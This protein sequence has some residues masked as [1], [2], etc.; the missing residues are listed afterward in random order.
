MTRSKLRSVLFIFAAHVNLNNM[1]NIS[2]TL[3]L[4]GR[5]SCEIFGVLF[6][7]IMDQIFTSCNLWLGR[8]KKRTVK[9]NMMI[10]ICGRVCVA[11]EAVRNLRTD[12]I[13]LFF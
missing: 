8:R 2:N 9:S 3:Q 7:K 10:Q 4:Q 13:F 6:L 1:L 11:L 12:Y 5:E